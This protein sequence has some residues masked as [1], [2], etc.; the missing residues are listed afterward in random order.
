MPKGETVGNVVID[1]KGGK[2]GNTQEKEAALKQ[3]QTKEAANTMEAAKKQMKA[4]ETN[5]IEGEL[6]SQQ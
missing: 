2:G 3:R 4:E 6:L 1:G 5:I